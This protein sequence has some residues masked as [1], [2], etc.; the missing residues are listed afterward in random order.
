M[1]DP[2]VEPLNPVHQRAD[3][4][5]GHASL[6][7]L[8]KRYAGQYASKLG[9]TDV[10]VVEGQPHILGYYTLAPSHFEFAHAPAEL[11]K[12]LPKH[13]G[14]LRG[15]APE[16]RAAPFAGGGAVPELR[17]KKLDRGGWPLE[18]TRNRRGSGIAAMSSGLAARAIRRRE[19]RR[20]PKLVPH[21]AHAALDN[22]SG[23]LSFTA[24]TFCV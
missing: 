18:G 7:N 23:D 8:L 1:V 15:H 12:G 22:G 14:R 10:A 11:L 6:D 19:S 3:F 20:R 9:T 24:Y 13:P 5:C 4:S 2:I 17:Q 16:G 21:R